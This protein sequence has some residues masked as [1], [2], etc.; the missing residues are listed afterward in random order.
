MSTDTETTTTQDQT[1]DQTAKPS[2]SG[3]LIAVGMI[4]VLVLL[5]VLNM[6]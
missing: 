3:L 4:A 5:I 6:N 1:T 2:K